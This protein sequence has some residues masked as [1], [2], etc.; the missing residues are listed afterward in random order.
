MTAVDEE[1]PLFPYLQGGCP[2]L[3][4]ARDSLLR[5]GYAVIPSVFSKEECAEELSR[6]WD[7]I[8]A[9]APGVRRG[10]EATWY[11]SQQG[12]E[13]GSDA[14]GGGDPWPHSGWK[15][16]TDML[17]MAEAGFVFS[18]LKERLAA[19]VF[20]RLYGTRELHASK[21]GFTFL[22]PTAGGQHPAFRSPGRQGRRRPFVCGQEVS[23]RH[24]GEHFDQRAGVA[25]LRCVQSSTALLDQDGCSDG[26]FLCWPGSHKDHAAGLVN[27]TWRGR[28]DW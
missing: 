23:E 8:E 26:C 6:L 3:E 18:S 25:G 15:S 20:Q 14:E 16:F 17:Q 12:S 9:K 1:S 21:E 11:P 13:E 4:S 22:R 24:Q 2:S 5:D 19:R 28:S 10:D 7:F 27:G